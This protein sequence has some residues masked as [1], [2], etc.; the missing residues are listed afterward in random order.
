MSL[1]W[2]P[3]L[4]LAGAI[5]APTPAHAVID[6]QVAG[7]RA[8][9]FAAL[10]AIKQ[11]IRNGPMQELDALELKGAIMRDGKIDDAERDLLEEMTQS[12]FRGITVTQAGSST[13]R[14]IVYPTS[15]HAKMALQ[16]TLSPPLNLEAK[17]AQG[18]AG[19]NEIVANYRKG[20]IE[21]NRVVNFVA[22][23]L[24]ADWAASNMGN[25]YK[26][27]RDRIAQLHGYSG[28]PGA[29]TTNGRVILYK[30]MKK[31]DAEQNDRVPDFLYNWT[32]PAAFL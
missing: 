28:T 1:R 11:R 21:E 12:Q 19:W 6:G 5:L 13:T 2:V 14:V 25:S 17:W 18:T 30:A 23:K 27:L 26:P 7:L 10:S 8:D 24:G 15:G 32:R 9:T 31:L 4:L 29:D 16:N 20:A 22:A 3:A